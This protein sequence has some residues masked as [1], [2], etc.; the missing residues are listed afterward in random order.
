VINLPAI[1]EENTPLWPDAYDLAAL[2]NI[3]LTVGEYDWQCLYQQDPIPPHGIIV[4]PEWMKVGFQEGGYSAMMIGIDPAVGLKDHNDE[5]AIC[6]GGIGFGPMPKI[7][8][9]QTIYGHWTM[10]Q[11]VK[12]V[13][14]LCKKNEIDMVGVEDV[15]SQRWLMQALADK[16]INA[17]PLKT[18]GKDKVARF[19]GISQYMTQGRVS[20]NTP[21]LREQLLRFRGAGEKN[22]LVDAFVY[23]MILM[24]DYTSERNRIGSEDEKFD[25]PEHMNPHAWF[26][27][28][29]TKQEH[30]GEEGMTEDLIDKGYGGPA[31]SDYF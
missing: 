17:W 4:K 19:M 23:M 20:I 15:Q 10:E 28:Q 22:D 29:A 27:K 21:K 16:G 3:R 12:L 2:E 30:L 1:T 14:A 26:Y 25:L 9:I 31:N 13:V 24:R 6:V 7:D 11:I 8:E 18:G 5:T